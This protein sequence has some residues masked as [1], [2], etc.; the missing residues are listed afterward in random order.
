MKELVEENP[1]ELR[2]PGMRGADG[3]KNREIDFGGMETKYDR[4]DSALRSVRIFL[5]PA[6][7]TKE[8]E[9]H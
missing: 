3:A 9:H 4:I 2:I 7:E 8:N 6:S 5:S 1:T